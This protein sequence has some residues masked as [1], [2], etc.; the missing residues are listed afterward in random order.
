MKRILNFVLLVLVIVTIILAF[1][2]SS[3]DTLSTKSEVS[4]IQYA[5][6]LPVPGTVPPK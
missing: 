1:Q 2:K 5:A 4:K 6:R 3:N